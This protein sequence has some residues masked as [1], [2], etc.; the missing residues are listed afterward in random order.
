MQLHELACSYMSL[1]AVPL[2]EQLTRISQC[3]FRGGVGNF[4][5]D[6][7]SHF[8]QKVDVLVLILKKISLDNL[9]S[10][11]PFERDYQ[12]KDHFWGTMACCPP[13]VL[14]KCFHN[15]KLLHIPWPWIIN[16]FSSLK[17]ENFFCSKALQSN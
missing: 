14:I 6:F 15:D 12:K 4:D 5:L 10:W 2:S 17:S 11:C 9:R 1:H 13:N 7:L 16:N 8:S 3:L